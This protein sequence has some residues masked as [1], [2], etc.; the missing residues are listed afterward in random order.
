MRTLSVF[1][2]LSMFAMQPLAAQTSYT[3]FDL[4]K[5][6][7][8][9]APESM[10]D[11]LAASAIC[12][13]KNKP[14][15]HFYEG[16]LRQSVSF[17]A[18]KP[19]ESFGGFNYMNEVIEWRADN[20]GVIFAAINRFYVSYYDQKL[21]DFD[22][23]NPSQIL[24]VHRVAQSPNDQSC[25]VGLVDARANKNANQ[26]ARQIADNLAMSFDCLT[27]QPQY[28]GQKGDNTAAHFSKPQPDPIAEPSNR[29]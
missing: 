17:G 12:K 7:K 21:G 10:L 29:N 20:N 16:D 26:L 3:K 9:N 18:E 14:N 15:M 11:G 22:P 2:M 27:A 5:D 13:F 1:I 19:F 28:H 25:I 24:M 4:D 23:D 6:C 8:W